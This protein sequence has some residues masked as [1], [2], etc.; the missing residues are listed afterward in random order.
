[1]KK[2]LYSC[3]AIFL[4]LSLKAQDPIEKG[5]QFWGG[6]IGASGNFSTA[7]YAETGDNWKGSAHSISLK[8]QWGTFV[9]PNLMLGVGAQGL[10]QPNTNQSEQSGSK[11]SNQ[12][13][14]YSFSPFVRWYKPVTD[15]FCL[16]AEP[17]LSVGWINQRIKSTSV[18]QT[19]ISKESTFNTGL[20]VV[21]GL[22]Y[23][24]GKRFALEADLNIFQLGLNYSGSGSY[25]GL[26]FS[27][28]LSS[29]INSY[30][31]LRGAFYLH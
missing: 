13:Y 17:A 16:F 5:T 27:S 14:H 26:S 1:M 24:L 10:F 19:L 21:P 28:S 18:G 7:K 31:S 9:K 23:R 22:S 20:N 29:E 8:I 3:L 12:A 30:F 2:L 4:V 15:R 25:K 6:T 11:Y